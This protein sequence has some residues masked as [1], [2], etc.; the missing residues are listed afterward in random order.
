LCRRALT[1]LAERTNDGE[2]RIGAV[3]LAP[4]QRIDAL[5]IL[6]AEDGPTASLA[7]HL[8]FRGQLAD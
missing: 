4:A 1:A 8:C 3:N 6:I 2:I 5:R 7:T